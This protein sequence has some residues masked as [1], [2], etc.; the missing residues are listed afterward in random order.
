MLL[1][2]HL[3]EAEG[4]SGLP[5]LVAVVE[6]TDGVLHVA[7][8][9]HV[10]HAADEGSAMVAQVVVRVHADLVA[11]ADVVLDEGAVAPF[12][13]VTSRSVLVVG[14]TNKQV[15]PGVEGLLEEETLSFVLG[16][17]GVD[18][19]VAEVGR[20]AV[21]VVE[22]ARLELE[23]AS[24]GVGRKA[25]TVDGQVALRVAP[26][27]HG[28]GRGA[29]PVV[30]AGDE[31]PAVL[32]A[33]LPGALLGHELHVGVLHRVG[34]DVVFHADHDVVAGVGPEAEA[35]PVP[36]VGAVVVGEGAGVAG[37]AVD[38]DGVGRRRRSRGNQGNEDQDR[39][40]GDDQLVHGSSSR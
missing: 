33:E 13:E 30:H 34:R 23:V 18:G 31:P 22:V 3:V 27:S 10:A 8:E 17:P 20:V 5:Q 24:L 21:A 36:L 9:E 28:Q 6:D 40:D 19:S 25:G 39:N 11:Q 26:A 15:D 4:H 32:C 14:P 29:R 2:E 35:A 38:L 1:A 37:E 16:P 12:G 7:G